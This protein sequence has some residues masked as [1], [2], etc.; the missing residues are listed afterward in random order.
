MLPCVSLAETLYLVLYPPDPN[1]YLP[2]Q[3]GGGSKNI[4][5][6]SP[7]KL[8]TAPIPARFTPF[9]RPSHPLTLFVDVFPLS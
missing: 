7:Q 1:Y 6:L 4:R 3:D 5:P 2:A 8:P 9:K